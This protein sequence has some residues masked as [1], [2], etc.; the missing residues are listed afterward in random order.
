MTKIAIVAPHIDDEL[1][2]C[3]SI[4]EQALGDITVLYLNELSEER[5]REAEMVGRYFQSHW[6]I[7]PESFR[8]E[9]FDQVYVPCRQDMHPAHRSANAIYRSAATHFYSTDMGEGRQYLGDARSATKRKWLDALYP[10]QRG[11]WALN[12]G[13][14]L[15]ENIRETDVITYTIKN[16]Y[17]HK[18]RVLAKY[19]PL[20]DEIRGRDWDN[21]NAPLVLLELL[22]KR[23][24]EGTISITTPD[25]TEYTL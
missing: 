1:I 13:Y 21:G 7:M 25:G 5:L 11:L 20:V 15:F 10:S 6:T 18:V 14:Y 23:C 4:F 16:V 19:A 9:E 2:G 12:S 8:S 3:F 22:A 17:K 24:L